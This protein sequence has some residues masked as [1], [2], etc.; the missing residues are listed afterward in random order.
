MWTNCNIQQ[1]TSTL[2]FKHAN[3]KR[4]TWLP[5]SHHRTP[6]VWW[7]RRFSEC[8][9]SPPSGVQDRLYCEVQVHPPSPPHS[10]CTPENTHAGAH[11]RRTHTHFITHTAFAQI[12][13]QPRGTPTGSN[14]AFQLA[15]TSLIS[16]TLYQS[17]KNKYALIC[18]NLHPKDMY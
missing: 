16:D 13:Q 2:T 15:V 17:P 11:L 1:H 6:C 9:C 3:L 14:D 4:E 5:V 12:S 8:C 18:I 10:M 7:W